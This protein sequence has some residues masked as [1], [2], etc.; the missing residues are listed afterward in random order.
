LEMSVLRA[1]DYGNNAYNKCKTRSKFQRENL[2]D[3]Y[4]IG[5]LKKQGLSATPELIK[6]ERIRLQLYR[7]LKNQKIR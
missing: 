1:V 6:L 7:E 3:E 5:V 4:L 2:T